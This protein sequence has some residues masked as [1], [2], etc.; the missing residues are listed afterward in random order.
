MS[1]ITYPFE[2]EHAIVGESET[3]ADI[4]N[5]VAK[6]YLHR[7]IVTATDNNHGGVTLSHD[8]HSHV[9][10]PAGVGKGVYSIELNLTSNATGWKATTGSH[11]T[12]IAV[13]KVP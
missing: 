2:F 3:N 5:T 8:D 7:V 13:Y 12:L 4:G 6:T 10:V 9:I 1:G 11:S